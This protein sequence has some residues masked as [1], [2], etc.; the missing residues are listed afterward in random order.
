MAITPTQWARIYAKAW[1]EYTQGKAGFQEKLEMDPANA[2]ATMDPAEK[3]QFGIGR[4]DKIL[5][6]DYEDDPV[7]QQLKGSATQPLLAAVI[8]SGELNGTKMSSGTWIRPNPREEIHLPERA[9]HE[10]ISPADW[11]RIYAYIWY[12]Y[13]F[14]NDVTT[15]ANFEKDPASALT[16][17]VA[18]IKTFTNGK[19][20]INYT[21]G[22]TRLLDLGLPPHKDK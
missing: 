21:K 1:Y 6:L 2:I 15:R 4:A 12:Q 16:Q 14:K 11:T 13:S 5:D 7:A 22:V 8:D 10:T 9:V 3:S 19:V 20:T 18:D 17:I